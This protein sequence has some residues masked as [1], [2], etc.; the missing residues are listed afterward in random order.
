VQ[1]GTSEETDGNVCCSKFSRLIL[2][3]FYWLAVWNLNFIFSYI[4]NKNP[5]RGVETTNQ[6][7]VQTQQAS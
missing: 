7:L 2:K 5:N 4:G 6:L 3:D 1:A